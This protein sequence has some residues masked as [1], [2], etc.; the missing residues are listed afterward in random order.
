MHADGLDGAATGLHGTYEEKMVDVF[1]AP[2]SQELDGFDP[3]TLSPKL[4]AVGSGFEAGLAVIELM[5][6]GHGALPPTTICDTY[7]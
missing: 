5:R 2:L 7:T 3:A 4:A 6:R 1:A